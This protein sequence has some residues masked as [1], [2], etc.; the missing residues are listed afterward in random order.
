MSGLPS[1]YVP[2]PT[3]FHL[4]PTASK[5]RVSSLIPMPDAHF[6]LVTSIFHVPA[7]GLW[8]EIV[9]EETHRNAKTVIALRTRP[10]RILYPS[11]GSRQS[12]AVKTA[13]FRFPINRVL[14]LRFFAFTYFPNIN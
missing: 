12:V 10:A 2:V 1:E 5:V 7:N 9:V 13:G 4:S 14:P 11:S 8:A 3:C 6:D